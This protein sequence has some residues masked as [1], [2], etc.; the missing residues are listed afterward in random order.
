MNG[1]RSV[2]IVDQSEETREVLQ[3][4]LERRGVRN[5]TDIIVVSDH[6]FS[7]ISRG[8]DLV[9][10]LKKAKFNAATQFE[11][12]EAG[13]V[14]VINLGGTAFFYVFEHDEAVTRKL[15]AFFNSC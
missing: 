14:L 5:E 1:Q 10:I 7:T 8:F 12:P 6:G 4:A 13:D 3:T 9:E 11:N 15:A 2:L